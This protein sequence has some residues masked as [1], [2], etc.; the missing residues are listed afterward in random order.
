MVGRKESFDCV[1]FIPTSDVKHS[2]H[3]LRQL[4]Y[5][6]PPLYDKSQQYLSEL[7]FGDSSKPPYHF[8]LTI[9]LQCFVIVN[10]LRHTV[11]P[12]KPLLVVFLSYVE[13]QK[14]REQENK[15]NREPMNHESQRTREPEKRRTRKPEIT[16]EQQELHKPRKL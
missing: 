8:S 14:P 7:S 4:I 16:T 15:K 2:S 1:N 9:L 3:I 12:R 13:R 5:I 10:V 6:A 11:T